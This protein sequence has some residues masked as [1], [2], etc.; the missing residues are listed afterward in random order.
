MKCGVLRCR[1]V[2]AGQSC[3]TCPRL[4]GWRDMRAEERYELEA[5]IAG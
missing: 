5:K 1:L 3:D 2:E 4:P